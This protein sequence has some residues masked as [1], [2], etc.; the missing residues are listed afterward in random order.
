MTF[1]RA[2]LPGILLTGVALTQ[3]CPGCGPIEDFDTLDPT[4][5]VDACVTE[6]IKDC[7]IGFGSLAAGRRQSVRVKVTNLGEAVLNIS[8]VRLSD[9]TDPAF[10]ITGPIPTT[11]EMGEEGSQFIDLEFNP[12]VASS[13]AGELIIE[14]DAANVLEADPEQ[15]NV[16]VTLGGIGIDLG[17][18]HLTLSPPQC[19]FGEV[20]VNIP[21]FCDVSIGNDGQRELTITDV[22]YIP[23]N[24][25]V[26]SVSG[27]FPIPLGL[28]PGSATTVRVQFRPTVAQAYV[29]GIFM[30]TTDPTQVDVIIPLTG[31]GGANPTAVA[32]VLSV[33]GTPTTEASPAVRPLD[34]VVLTGADSAAGTPGRTIT[35]YTWELITRPAGSTVELTTPGAMTTGFSFNSSGSNRPGI[36][37]SGTFVA[38]LTVR[39]DAGVASTNDARVTLNA[40]PTEDLNIQLTWDDPDADI[41]LHVVRGLGPRWGTNDCHYGNCKTPAV[42]NWGGG[43]ASPRLNVDDTDGFGPEIINIV[44]P[45]N[46]TYTVGVHNYRGRPGIEVTIKIT[47]QGALLGEY[48]RTL[49]ACD[50]W[51]DV[52]RVIWGASATVEDLNTVAIDPGSQDGC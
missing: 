35:G 18:P 44:Q 28:P 16:T 32:R 40:I 24:D 6:G 19:D 51:W 20:A 13:V 41:D 42:L 25:P 47:V 11:V 4:I 5:L 45:S 8:N 12:S 31:S 9:N 39:D 29:G 50:Q 49:T 7:S 43:D 33:N 3:G 2:L 30:T 46:G 17:Q 22:G 38:R 10:S 48:T 27:A 36:D 52:A 14:S 23:S 34:N 1:Q 37:V 21:A 15:T 26:F